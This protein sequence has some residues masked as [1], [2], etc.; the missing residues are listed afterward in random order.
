MEATVFVSYGVVGV[1][2][3]PERPSLMVGRAHLVAALCKGQLGRG[4]VARLKREDLL[5][6][7]LRRI[8]HLVHLPVSKDPGYVIGSV[9]HG[10]PEQLVP[11]RAADVHGGTK[12]LKFV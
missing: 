7:A 5:W 6:H 3:H 11:C 12:G 8:E 2:P 1:C 4:R 9:V 10:V